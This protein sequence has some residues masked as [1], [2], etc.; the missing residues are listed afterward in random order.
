MPHLVHHHLLVGALLCRIAGME[1]RWRRS[2]QRCSPMAKAGP[3][4]RDASLVLPCRDGLHREQKNLAETLSQ[5]QTG[6]AH[7]NWPR[8]VPVIWASGRVWRPVQAGPVVAPVVA[9]HDLV[10][11]KSSGRGL[12]QVEVWLGRGCL[13]LLHIRPYLLSVP[14]MSSLGCQAAT[15]SRYSAFRALSRGLGFQAPLTAAAAAAAAAVREL[16]VETSPPIHRVPIQPPQEI[17]EV[18]VGR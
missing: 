9:T 5:T 4:I 2:D 10:A 13:W 14:L 1:R 17:H 6:C 8:A 15:D 3:Q 7:S 12:A 18:P 11:S 16:V